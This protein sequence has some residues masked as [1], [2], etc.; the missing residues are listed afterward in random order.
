MDLLCDDVLYEIY[1][2]LDISD[3]INCSSVCSQFY[4]VYKQSRLWFYLVEKIDYSDD[5]DY[6]QLFDKPTYYETYKFYYKLLVVIKKLNLKYS[7]R[8]FSVRKLYNLQFLSLSAIHLT[9]IPSELENLTNLQKLDLSNNQLVKIPTELENLINLQ[10][11]YLY[12]NQLAKIPSELGNLTNLQWLD[13]SHNRLVEIPSE[14]GNLTNLQ[15]LWLSNNQLTEI[16]S[17]L[18]NLINLQELDL[19]NSQSIEIPYEIK[20]IPIIRIIS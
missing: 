6:K 5:A 15:R 9:E 10:K 16:P 18:G 2:H 8:N 17:E 13:L 14:L 12:N 19:Y 3:I 1:K 11:L 7:A 4:N 20:Q